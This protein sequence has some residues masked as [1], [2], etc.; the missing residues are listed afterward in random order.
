MYKTDW[1]FINRGLLCIKWMMESNKEENIYKTICELHK[2]KINPFWPQGRLLNDAFLLMSSFILFIYPLEND[3]DN[4]DPKNL[5]FSK[6]HIMKD[7]KNDFQDKKRFLKR[8]RNGIAHS[9]FKIEDSILTIEDYN[10][11][12]QNY[13]QFYI[14]IVEFGLFIDQFSHEVNTQMIQKYNIP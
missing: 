6:F 4:I 13:I 8:I 10:N 9:N 11:S 3:F 1:E 2:E 5:D 14:P 7:L 12:K